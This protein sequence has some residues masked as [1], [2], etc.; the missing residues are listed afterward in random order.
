M[1]KMRIVEGKAASAFPHSR[2]R[3]VNTSRNLTDELNIKRKKQKREKILLDS[4]VAREPHTTKWNAMKSY[5]MII[6]HLSF[7]YSSDSSILCIRNLC[8]C[9]PNKFI[10][11]TWLPITELWILNCAQCSSFVANYSKQFAE[12]ALGGCYRPSVASKQSFIFMIILWFLWTGYHVIWIYFYISHAIDF[13]FR[14]TQPSAGERERNDYCY[15]A[16]VAKH[17]THDSNGLCCRLWCGHLSLLW[18][19]NDIAWHGH[20]LELEHGWPSLQCRL[21]KS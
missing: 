18:H 13:Y 1:M 9:F 12:N 7:H 11:L 6:I 14:K 15:C 16:V 2:Q 19:F 8:D 20:E 5:K 21:P 10:R 3:R 17:D 4:V